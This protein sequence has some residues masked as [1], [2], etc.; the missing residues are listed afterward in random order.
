MGVKN[1]SEV[2]FIVLNSKEYLSIR[3]LFRYSLVLSNISHTIRD[4][5]RVETVWIKNI[6]SG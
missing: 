3:V 4:I 6:D 1:E 5:F 2:K